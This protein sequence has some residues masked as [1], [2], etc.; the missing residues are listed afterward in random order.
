VPQKYA[1]LV[2]INNYKYPDRVPTLAGS[3]N[4]VDDMRQVLI[5]KFEF[6][7]ENIL[8]L[9]DAEATHAA[10]INAIKTQLIAKAKAGDIVIFDYSGHGSQ[11]R[12]VTGKMISGRDE[13]IVPYDSRDPQNKIFDISGAE[14]HPLLQQLAAKTNNVTFILDSCHSGTLVRG[15]RVRGIAEDT[16]T[17][18]PLPKESTTG[19]TRSAGAM[20]GAEPKFAFIAAASSQESAFEQQADG[21]DHGA[22]TYFLTRQLRA[23]PAGATY[24]DIMDVVAGSVNATNPAQHPALEGAG[25]DQ[26]VFGD[27]TSL[28]RN[29]VVASPSSWDAQ[30]VTLGVGQVEG[31]TVGSLYDVYLPGSR[32][33]GPPEVALARVRITSVGDSAAE[34]VPVSGGK[35]TPASRAVER[36]HRFA[37]RQVRLFLDGPANSPVLVS[38]HA[39]LANV[40]YIALV[41]KPTLCNLQLRLNGNE[42]AILSADASPLSPPLAAT[43]PDASTHA[44]DELKSWAKWFGVLSI[45]N[46]Q[47]DITLRFALK[48]GKSRDAIARVGR[49]NLTVKDG[50]SV[51]ATVTNLGGR[52]VYVAMLDL[53]SD[54]SVSVIYPTIQ[55]E[56][57]VLKGGSELLRSFHASVPKGRPSV[58]DVIKVFASYKP[59]DLLPLTQARVRAVDEG[60]KGSDPL[61][62]L[63]MDS[64]GVTRGLTPIL[65]EPV[66][67]TT[68]TTTQASLVV[69]AH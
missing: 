38:I 51:E 60:Q 22:L 47:S 54:G 1:L 48:A 59:I 23:A 57:E 25:A 66:E 13:T 33:F 24:R 62:E 53:S 16:R 31:A 44:V 12:D 41:D 43:D 2:G 15:A 64:A 9:K 69:K 26:Q 58:S 63:L 11:M 40:K 67:L 4:D 36:E 61:Q 10:I 19:L 17:P 34:A 27:A 18:P 3:L 37:D 6:R 49:A 35:V 65:A 56:Q 42:L 20:E 28:A 45:H 55:G 68:W 8:V 21:K 30:H 52:D 29:Y 5:G 39:A 46:A 7:P 14:L 50:D 32:K